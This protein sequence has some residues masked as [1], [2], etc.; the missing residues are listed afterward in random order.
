MK[1]FESPES[2]SPIVTRAVAAGLQGLY[3]ENYD[4]PG[5]QKSALKL[6]GALPQGA[7]RFAIS[8]FQSLS[9]LPPQVLASFSLDDLIRARLSDYTQLN[10]NF[11]ALTVGAALGGATTYLSLATNS[12]FLPQTFVISLR[13]GS[14]SGDVNE[15]LR[16]SLDSALEIAEK[17]PRLMTIQHYDPIHDGWLTRFVNHLRFKL[18]DLPES[19]ADFIKKRLEPG[20]AV[21]YLEG[22][23]EWLRYRVGPRSV[24][25]IGGWGDIPARE[26]IDGSPRIS[27]YAKATGFTSDHWGLDADGEKRSLESGPESEWGTEPGLGEALEAFCKNE[28]FRFVRI[29]LAH[30]NDFSRLAFSAAETLLAKDGRVAAGTTVECF[31]QFDATASMQAGLL[32]LWLI[33]NTA[34][35]ARYL[36][37]MSPKFPK[38]K[39]IFVSPLSTFS[40]TPDMAA[41]QDWLDALGRADF[42]NTGARQ[43]HYPADARAIVEWANPLRAWVKENRQPVKARLTAEELLQL[44]ASLRSKV[45]S[46]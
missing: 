45:E 6:L 2:S 8:R 7:A 29:R 1:P 40:L 36:R 22:G 46:Q 28:G 16:R 26:F 33:F 12:I 13:G 31:S 3:A 20:G 30:P 11:P 15:Y 10:G 4:F 19:Y 14:T 21:I 44:S 25:Q 35:S 27:A 34:D 42:I 9:G 24:F 17:D 38:D 32:P 39:P 41:W 5:W 18:L 23:A 43:S 37:E